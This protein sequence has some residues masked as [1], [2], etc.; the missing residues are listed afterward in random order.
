MD[1]ILEI[2]KNQPSCITFSVDRKEWFMKMNDKG[3]FFNHEEYPDL[4]S[5]DFAK[6]F[7]DLMESKFKIKF[8]EIEE[9]NG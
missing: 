9:N 4:K 7:I 5:D 8:Y 3:I 6:E 1:K 2:K